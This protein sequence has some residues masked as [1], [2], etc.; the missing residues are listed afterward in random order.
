MKV[1]SFQVRGW[2][3]NPPGV[4]YTDF[5]PSSRFTA[6]V[7]IVVIL[8]RTLG[9][10]YTRLHVLEYFLLLFNLLWVIFWFPSANKSSSS[11]SEPA[12]MSFLGCAESKINYLQY[13][14]REWEWGCVCV[15][16]GDTVLIPITHKP[17][18]LIESDCIPEVSDLPTNICPPDIIN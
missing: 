11:S 8:R 6:W 12:S 1:W 18:Q 4:P 17:R 14:W 13:M 15:G 9:N 16:G 3:P 10:C 5:E 7:M 2:F